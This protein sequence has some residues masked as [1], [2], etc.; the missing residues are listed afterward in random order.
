MA[1]DSAFRS[2]VASWLEGLDKGLGAHAFVVTDFGVRS[3]AV[4]GTLEPDDI[5]ALGSCLIYRKA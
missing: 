4:M 3:V 2:W 5:D 1:D